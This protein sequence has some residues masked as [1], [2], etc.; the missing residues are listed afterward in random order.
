MSKR[1]L[2]AASLR[3][4][5]AYD[6]LTGVFTRIRENHPKFKVGQ[7]AGSTDHY[8]YTVLSIDN[9]A[10]KGHRLAWLHSYGD[11]PT[12]TL[13]HRNGVK[14][15]NRLANLREAGTAGNVTNRGKF[16]NNTSGYKGVSYCKRSRKW[17]A[18][19]QVN[20]VQK[21]LGYF[22]NP[23]D[24]YAAYCAAATQLHGEFARLN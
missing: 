20:R 5:F 16:S 12:G 19:V 2:T 10:Y 7:V 21:F 17:A 1:I 13:D 14:N 15:D 23:E 22:I 4:Q 6:P 8:G 3:E 24:A 9:V 18:N 11:W